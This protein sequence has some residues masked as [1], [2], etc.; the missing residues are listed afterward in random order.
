MRTVIVWWDLS[1]STQTIESLRTYLL[2]ESVA[3]FA[4][5][6]GLRLKVW[7]SDAETNRWGAI[8]LWESAQAAVQP[9]PSRA[10]ALIGY[11][12]TQSHVF[13]VEA[14]VEGRYEV[15]QLALRG[16][17]FEAT[18]ADTDDHRAAAAQVEQP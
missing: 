4:E 7:I 16:L 2:D 14:T 15:A 17:A 6:P 18:A 1:G 8:L 13:E 11:P 5:V 3:A 9:L 12:P 10:T